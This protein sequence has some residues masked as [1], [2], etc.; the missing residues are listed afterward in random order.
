MIIGFDKTILR[1]PLTGIGYYT[2]FLMR[3]LLRLEA[4]LDLRLY[5]GLRMRSS[6]CLS[7][8][9]GLPQTTSY[10]IKAYITQTL[11]GN[12][13]FRA[14]WRQIK[15]M[16]FHQASGQVDLFHA[17]NYLPPSPAGVP[18]L[19]LIHDVS[20]LR[21]PEWHPP[22]RVKWLEARA[23]EFQAAPLI[24]TVSE[25]SAGEIA[26]TLGIARERIHI[27]YPGVNPIYRQVGAA[28]PTVLQRFDLKSGRF[29]LCV[30]TL[31][32][33][34]NLAT[35][36]E[37]YARLPRN[38]QARYPLLIVGP[39]GWGSL[40]LPRATDRLV[41]RG[42]VRFPGYLDESVMCT[43]YRDCA[44]FL[45]PSRYEG[46]GMPVSE[47]MATGTRPL[48]AE[49][50][51]PEEVAGACGLALPATDPDRWTLALLTAI[52]EDWHANMPLRHQLTNASL[53][54][55]WSRNARETRDLYQLL[56]TTRE[57]TPND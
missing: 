17:T 27:T 33:R 2:Y 5:D 49:G 47:A 55:D 6:S 48:I 32:P 57:D 41:D 45:F 46:F 56:L 1:E 43:L 29:F 44:A 13:G 35:V 26:E 16:R 12:S 37:A 22:E 38:L 14:L 40:N 54:Y 4:D 9:S 19:P 30:G 7:Q 18:V 8:R 53:R 25:F 24:H 15:A 52:D 21:H 23:H 36:I 34:K 39:K 10:S 42:V 3:H 51:A 31:E 50:G 28:D 20:H 11:R